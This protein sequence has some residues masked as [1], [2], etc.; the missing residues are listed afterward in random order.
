MKKRNKILFAI[1]LL[2]LLLW[3]ITTAQT[4]NDFQNSSFYKKIQQLEIPVWN[5]LLWKT[6]TRY[7]FTRLLN[8]IECQDCIMPDATMVSKYNE[9]SWQQFQQL[10]WKYFEDIEYLS[11]THNWTNYYYCVANIWSDDIMNWYPRGTSICWWKFCW[12][13]NVTKAEFF[14]TLSN[15]LMDRNM[16]N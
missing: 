1:P 14:Q 15:F 9:E 8:A 13:R 11:W 7:D 4:S 12:Q 2:L 10:P 6:L 3:T 16:F 5:I